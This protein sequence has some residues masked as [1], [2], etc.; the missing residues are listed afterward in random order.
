MVEHDSN[1]GCVPEQMALK[2]LHQ[3]V[4]AVKYIH[5]RNIIHRDI[6]SANML[7]K[8]DFTVKLSDFGFA[9]FLKN[10]NTQEKF[11]VGSP[12]YMSPEAQA[13]QQH[14]VKSDTWAL[15]MI[16]YEMLMGRQPFAYGDMKEIMNMICNRTILTTL[17]SYVSTLSHH[18]L[19]RVWMVDPSQRADTTELLMLLDQYFGVENQNMAMGFAYLNQNTPY[20]HPQSV[21]HFH[22]QQFKGGRQI[23][24][25]TIN[26]VINYV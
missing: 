8:S 1:Q 4:R 23:S 10:H 12:L 19:N 5:D 7:L 11:N 13:Y 18:I 25:Q 22:N 20:L 24:M 17:P 2:I 6:K 14:S 16:L 3:I 15:G 26:S 21:A 9:S